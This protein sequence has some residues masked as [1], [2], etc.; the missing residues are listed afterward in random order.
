MHHR[1]CPSTAWDVLKH[2]EKKKYNTC[3]ARRRGCTRIRN[4]RNLSIFIFILY[5]TEMTCI[6]V[7]PRCSKLTV[8]YF[9]ISLTFSRE[10]EIWKWG[11]QKC[12]FHKDPFFGSW[13]W[14]H[15]SL[16]YS[17]QLHQPVSEQVAIWCC[18]NPFEKSAGQIWN[19]S[20]NLGGWKFWTTNLWNHHLGW[21]KIG[22][23]PWNVNEIRPRPCSRDDPSKGAWVKP[24]LSKQN[25]EATS[26]GF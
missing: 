4:H 23:I 3:N 26:K 21:Q 24:T 18:F 20:H 12:R 17:W 22:K 5:Y 14:H 11:N 8:A 15:R 1:F 16:I 6:L 2:V 10:H 19:H 7:G 9:R 13:N 25:L